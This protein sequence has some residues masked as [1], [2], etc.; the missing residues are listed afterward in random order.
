[1]NQDSHSHRSIFIYM[2]KSLWIYQLM[3]KVYNALSI[4]WRNVKITQ[5]VHWTLSWRMHQNINYCY[6]SVIR[7]GILLYFFFLIVF[8]FPLTTF[9]VYICNSHVYSGI[10]WI[11]I[12]LQKGFGDIQMNI[13]FFIL[14]DCSSQVLWV[15]KEGMPK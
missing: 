9:M 1:M 8:F 4:I 7:L 12:I 5:S 14:E 2:K 10:Y 15:L 11:S 6:L 13:I 3:K